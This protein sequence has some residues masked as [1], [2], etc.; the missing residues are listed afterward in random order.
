MQNLKTKRK[1]IMRLRELGTA[2]IVA[3]ASI[4]L[5]FGAL[6]IS[7][8][9]FIPEATAT[10][11]FA[12]PAS[13]VPVTATSTLPPTATLDPALA[14]AT[15]TATNTVSAS[16]SCQP[17]VG[18]IPIVIQLNDTLDT[19]STRYRIDKNVL[20]N[21][22]C[23]VSDNLIS[24]TL[25]FVPP[26]P[27]STF[28]ACVPGAVG[29]VKSYTVVKDDTMYAISGNYYTT[30]TLLKSVN[31]KTTDQ[32]K[33]G[34]ILWVPN[35]AT[36]TP[37]PTLLPGVTASPHP[38]DPLTQTA[39]PFTVTVIPSNTSIPN[40]PTIVSTPTAI[41]TLTASPTAFGNP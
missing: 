34:E 4:G 25:F 36:R 23:L 16:S 10:A 24:G 8:V 28:V 39:L 19:L 40:T 41:P 3:F 35:V 13:P 22:N 37:Y 32:I 33:T 30:V 9:E 29:W 26:A 1:E 31:C 5:I 18:W 17:P 15:F 11:T 6:S 7:L 27:T 21:A 14:T 12:L 38:T 2:L 20:R